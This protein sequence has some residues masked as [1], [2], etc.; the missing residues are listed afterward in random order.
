MKYDY[1][2]MSRE[3]L[4]EAAEAGDET[5][6]Q[7]YGI[8]LYNE[9]NK[10]SL[11]YF[12]DA[13]E[14]GS[15]YSAYILYDTFHTKDDSVLAK[16]VKEIIEQ[17]MEY[18][19]STCQYEIEKGIDRDGRQQ[20][21]LALV[22]LYDLGEKLGIDRK[23]GMEYYEAALE[24]GN[25]YAI[26]MQE[27]PAFMDPEQMRAYTEQQKA[28]GNSDK[29]AVNETRKSP[30]KG[31]KA[32]WLL[33]LGVV[34]ALFVFRKAIIGAAVSIWNA[35]L[36]IICVVFLLIIAYIAYGDEKGSSTSK[37]PEYD[38]VQEYKD[39][40]DCRNMPSCIYDDSGNRWDKRHAYENTAVY[41]NFD[42]GEV[43]ITYCDISSKYASG[44]RGKFHW[45]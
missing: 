6:M 29:A 39:N 14:R 18:L 28:Q 2:N 33:G 16:Q 40:H 19:V 1:L 5:A 38:P 7:Q 12:K 41:D 21:A 10:A 25:Q 3:E 42:M 13:M 23:K 36:P 45:Y 32:L 24:K 22:G 8:L 43:T 20:F 4:K 37:E 17:Q 15:I 9:G 30:E 34:I 44:N 31:G 26:F 11:Y 27:N 35:C